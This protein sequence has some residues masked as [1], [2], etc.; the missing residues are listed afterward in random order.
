MAK[1]LNA[2]ARNRQKQTSFAKKEMNEEIKASN[3]EMR[4]R[5]REGRRLDREAGTHR[6]VR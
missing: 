1:C 5:G 3:E 4:E 6:D 2:G